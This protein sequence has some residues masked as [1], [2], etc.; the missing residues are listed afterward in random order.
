M[1]QDFLTY[2]EYVSSARKYYEGVCNRIGIPFTEKTEVVVNQDEEGG[3]V[4]VRIQGVL[5]SFFG[6]DAHGLIA[7]LD[8]LQP[9][10][11]T[12]LIESPG[13]NVFD[14]LALWNDF[15]ARAEEGTEIVTEARGGVASAA[16]LAFLA[17]D[18]RYMRTGTSLMIHLA[19]VGLMVFGNRKVLKAAYTKAD[20][21]LEAI[22]GQVEEIIASR[23]GKD[24]KAVGEWVEAETWFSPKE[25]LDEGFATDLK[26]EAKPDKEAVN[27]A[28]LEEVFSKNHIERLFHTL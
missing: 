23:T 10:K 27:N 14:G 2:E 28:A 22:D 20:N 11:L 3:A 19:M 24:S 6:F 18:T 4:T 16:V 25:A 12:V 17:G 15:R 9:K 1:E 21:A 13:G 26:E 8:E 5:S 7:R